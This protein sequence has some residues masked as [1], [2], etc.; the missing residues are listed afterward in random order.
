MLKELRMGLGGS[1]WYHYRGEMVWVVGKLPNWR[2]PT[3]REQEVLVLDDDG[4]EF[5][6]LWSELEAFEE[7]PGPTRWDC[8]REQIRQL[9][10][11]PR[12]LLRRVRNTPAPP[13]PMGSSVRD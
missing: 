11:L 5:V 6:L 10:R 7:V 13:P 3:W 12:R 1:G 8:R 9:K 2:G 4:K